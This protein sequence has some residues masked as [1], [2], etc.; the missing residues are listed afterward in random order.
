L[1]ANIF[2][3]Q[4]RPFHLPIYTEKMAHALISCQPT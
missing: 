1:Q 4:E 3:N 2:V